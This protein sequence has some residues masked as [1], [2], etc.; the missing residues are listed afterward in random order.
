MND[1]HGHRG[2]NTGGKLLK[3]LVGSLVTAPLAIGLFLVLASTTP[4]CFEFEEP[5]LRA[6]HAC[7]AVV[8]RLGTP[9]ETATFGWSC[10]T[11]ETQGEFG[12]AS[13]TFPVRGPRGSAQV[14]VVA[15][16]RGGPWTLLR[17]EAT[18]DDRTIDVL[19]CARAAEAATR[20]AVATSVPGSDPT[21]SSPRTPPPAGTLRSARVHRV[22]ATIQSTTPGAP[23]AVGARCTIELMEHAAAACEATVRCGGLLVYH[24]RRPSCPADARGLLSYTD[25]NPTPASNPPSPALSVVLGSGRA[26]L[27][28]QSP[29]GNTWLVALVF[30]PPPTR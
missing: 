9:L 19:A 5:T 27:S 14:A 29:D 8:E 11:A 13:W 28:D 1:G 24:D 16:R 26:T 20:P 7:P 10:G 17:L 2:T 22:D 23:L 4:S 3:A 12:R 21:V 30:A 15:E 18:V 6:M 25:V